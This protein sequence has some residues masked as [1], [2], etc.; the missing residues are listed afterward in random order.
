MHWSSKM[1][2]LLPLVSSLLLLL[3]TCTSLELGEDYADVQGGGGGG[4]TSSRS[5][6]GSVNTEEE[7]PSSAKALRNRV[8]YCTMNALFC[9]PANYSK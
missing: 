9:I 8:K 4:V 7:K 6:V 3:T 1:A 5:N 2:S